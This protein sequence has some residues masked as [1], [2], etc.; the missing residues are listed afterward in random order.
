MVVLCASMT[1]ACATPYV[2][3]PLAAHPSAATTGPSVGASAGGVFGTAEDSNLISVPYSEGWLRAQAGAGQLDFHMGPGVGSLG[4][5]FDL[6]PLTAGFGFAVEPF[7]GGGY[8]RVS[9]PDLGDGTGDD[10]AYTLV[11]AGGLRFHILIPSGDN[12]FYI[13]PVLGITHMETDQ[14][15]VG[16][17]DDIVTFG[18][19]VGM[20]LGGRPGTSIELTVHRLSP[21]DDFDTDL[22]IFGPSVAFQ[23]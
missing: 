13:S 19:A 17:I 12:F 7:G 11:L 4:Y 3:V 5:R 20:N 18:T 8:Y 9:E 21:S 22:W 2:A 14:S 23:L 15:D 1:G 16:E 10:S 6:Q